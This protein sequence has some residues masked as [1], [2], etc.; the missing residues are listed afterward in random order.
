MIGDR[1]KHQSVW[2]SWN[3]SVYDE[4]LQELLDEIQQHLSAVKY[5]MT[6]LRGLK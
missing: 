4:R 1:M 5:L 2:E 3:E 6:K